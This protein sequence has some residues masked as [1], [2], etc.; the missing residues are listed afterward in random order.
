M[1]TY[2][3]QSGR[4]VE[5]KT[6]EELDAVQWALRRRNDAFVVESDLATA[7]AT[8]ADDVTRIVSLATVAWSRERAMYLAERPVSTTIASETGLERAT[9]R[10]RR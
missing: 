5:Y 6:P 10:D 1:P 2:R 7:G 3:V 4:P 9:K 8:D